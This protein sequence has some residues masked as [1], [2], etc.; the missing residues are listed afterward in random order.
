MSKENDP[1]S[2][3]DLAGLAEG[4]EWP[5][6]MQR[7]RGILTDTDR[8]FLW[9]VKEYESPVSRSGRRG[10]IRDRFADGLRDL[11]Y[12]SMLDDGQRED[13]LA[14]IDAE[15]NPGELRD[16]VSTL[17]EFLYFGQDT[18]I[19]WLEE[20]V[21][22]GVLNGESRRVDDSTVYGGTEVNVEIDVSRGHDVDRLEEQLRSGQHHT[23][24]PA[25]IG[26]LVREGRID[27][28]D[29]EQLQPEGVVPPEYRNDG[30]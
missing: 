21:A 20:T 30:V 15:T 2:P 4:G 6:S 24:S 28:D 11:A 9:G 1:P 7:P 17:V 18:D 10:Q 5:E 26:V 19:E 12:L 8:R 29:L 16:A 27:P 3:A 22:H 23:L 13:V 25:E 14:K